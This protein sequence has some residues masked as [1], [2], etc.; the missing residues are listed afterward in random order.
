MKKRVKD[1]RTRRNRVI[2][3]D[4][5]TAKAKGIKLEAL[6]KQMYNVVKDVSRLRSRLDLPL[7]STM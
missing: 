4:K 5:M 7:F 3:D 1:I 6:S 2:N